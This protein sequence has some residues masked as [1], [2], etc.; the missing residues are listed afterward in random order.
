MYS[1][2]LVSLIIQRNIQKV[3]PVNWNYFYQKEL[4]LS[5]PFYQKELLLSAPFYQK[6]LLLSA[7]FYQ[8]ELLLS[9]PFYQK[10]LLF[11]ASTTFS[12]KDYYQEERNVYLKADIY[13]ARKNL[14]QL[15]PTQ[16]ILSSHHFNNKRNFLDIAG[17]TR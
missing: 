8:K 3:F 9:A 13:L 6:E 15:F 11:L 14:M 10:E 1:F 17:Q 5:A 7:P 2:S 12:S 4:L 16:V